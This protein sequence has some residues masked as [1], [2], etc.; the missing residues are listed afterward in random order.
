MEK[1]NRWNNVEPSVTAPRHVVLGVVAAPHWPWLPIS[2]SL[3]EDGV[4]NLGIFARISLINIASRI[5]R[6]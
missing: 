6:M 1:E 3:A 4:T 5:A 2:A